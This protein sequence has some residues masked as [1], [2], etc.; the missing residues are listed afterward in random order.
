MLW[1]YL[2]A[3]FAAFRGLQVGDSRGTY[4]VI[5]PSTA[6]GLCLSIAGINNRIDNGPLPTGTDLEAP[7]LKIAIGIPEG[8]QHQTAWLLH[9]HHSY[10]DNPSD[11]NHKAVKALS[12][13][14]KYLISPV[15]REY[16]LDFQAVLGVEGSVEEEIAA[17]IRGDRKR[18]GVPFAGCNGHFFE[19]IRI[20]DEP[21]RCRWLTR[22]VQEDIGGLS[23]SLEVNREQPAF[24]KSAIYSFSE[25]TDAAPAGSWTQVPDRC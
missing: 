8:H 5:P 21:P 19:D 22:G 13:G 17:G 10:P 20:L 23:L 3:P 7:S 12:A 9:Q 4:R 15:R 16:V 2:K 1:I 11:P 18:T 14:R 24:S 25:A 6:W